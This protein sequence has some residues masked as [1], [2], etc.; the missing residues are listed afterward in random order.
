M[1]QLVIQPA[2]NTIADVEV[3]VHA[4]VTWWGGERQA[5]RLELRVSLTKQP[6]VVNQFKSLRHNIQCKSWLP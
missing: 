3:W 6:P 4:C 5:I 1:H 2:R